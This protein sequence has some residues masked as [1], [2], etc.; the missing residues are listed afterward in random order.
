MLE[1]HRTMQRPGQGIVR[2]NGATTQHSEYPKHMAH[3]GFQ[4]GK[5]GSEVKS[6]HGFS[7]HVG[8]EA[9]R[10]PPVLVQNEDQEEY[11]KS[12]GYVSIGKSDPAAFARAVQAAA[13]QAEHHEPDQYP[14]WIAALGRAV[15]SAEEEAELLGL[16][17]PAPPA[18]SEEPSA[19]PALSTEVATLL[20]RPDI[21]AQRI[22]TLEG[23]VDAIA[24]SFERMEAMLARIAG[25]QPAQAAPEPPMASAPAKP[26]RVTPP[27]KGKPQ[28]SA[29]SI[30]RGEKI[31][32][33]LAAKRA[34]EE[35]AK[36]TEKPT[37]AAVADEGYAV[38]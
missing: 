18:S 32:A 15:A 20:D 2:P 11:H 29:E 26:Q 19:T 36:S 9:I 37:E 31:K 24:S 4:P 33:G 35:A 23:K 7:Y 30:A 21:A 1:P 5:V 34:A 27:A 22:T 17:P 25:G 8:G 16:P 38:E 3:P 13:P 28:R 6:P 12:Q 10:F 14:K